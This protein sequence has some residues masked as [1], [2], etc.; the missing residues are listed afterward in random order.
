MQVT[1]QEMIHINSSVLACVV[2]EVV[3]YSPFEN[4]Q[5]SAHIQMMAPDRPSW[6]NCLEFELPIHSFTHGADLS[7]I[8]KGVIFWKPGINHEREFTNES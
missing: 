5:R 1:N 4:L 3:M 8:I 7:S 2:H 6:L